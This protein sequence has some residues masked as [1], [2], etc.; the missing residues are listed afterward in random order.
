MKKIYALNG[1]PRKNWNTDQMLDSFIRGIRETA[2]E[3]QVEKL[4]VYDL[5]YKGC[6][7][8]LGCR[9]K[10]TENGQC[11]CRDGAWSLLREIKAADGLVLASPI[12][13]SEVTAQLRALL[14]RIFYPGPAGKSLPVACIYTLNQ[15]EEVME[16]R[17][18]PHLDL[19][20]NCL[21]R[22]FGMEVEEVFS[23]ETLHWD[24]PER[25]EF[26]EEV[27]QARVRRRAE[28]FPKDLQNAYDAGERMAEKCLL[29]TE[30]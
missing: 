24:H 19:L 13:Y 9:M 22:T 12:Y 30:A 5:D 17:F 8:C 27:Y 3:I 21:A 6:R 1:G 10:S 15:P 11:V 20:K 14:E 29:G 16:A 28:Q 2:P 25:Y 4:H 18:R 26:S 23:F 7:G